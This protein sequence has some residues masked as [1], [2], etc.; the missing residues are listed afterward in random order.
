MK[1]DTNERPWSSAGKGRVETSG[2]VLSTAAHGV[3]WAVCVVGWLHP[4]AVNI[5]FR[6]LHDGNLPKK[7]L[8]KWLKNK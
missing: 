6:H 1:D 4:W 3:L 2:K 7:K 8:G 5:L